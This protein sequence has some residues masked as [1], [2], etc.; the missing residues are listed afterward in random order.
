MPRDPS[1]PPPRSL[2]SLQEP[3]LPQGARHLAHVRVL[4]ASKTPAQN[5][6]LRLFCLAVPAPR[7]CIRDVKEAFS[8]RPRFPGSF[9]YLVLD[10][11]DSE[12]QNLIRLFP[13]FLS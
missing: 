9:E 12:E 4:S 13:R 7:V 3:N 10:V 11:Q 5:P 2:P 1:W 6:E 8:V